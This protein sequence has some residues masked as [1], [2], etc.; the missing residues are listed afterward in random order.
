MLLSICEREKV[1]CL[2]PTI[3]TDLFLL[4]ENKCK[5]EPLG[6]KVLISRPEKVRICRDKNYTAD[7]FIFLGLKSPR[8]LNSVKKYEN[9]LNSGIQSFTADI[10]CDYDGKPVYI[11][12]RERMLNG[13][14]LTYIDKAAKD[15]AVYC[16]FDQSGCV[17]EDTQ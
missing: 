5:F 1:D 2:I 3:D 6:T 16:R 13:E 10:F 15:G 4:V 8:P 11:T 14:A 17:N 7:Y 12:P 9:E